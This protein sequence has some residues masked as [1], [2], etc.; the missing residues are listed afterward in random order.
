MGQIDPQLEYF[1]VRY[2]DYSIV[3]YIHLYCEDMSF[4]LPHIA[5]A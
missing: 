3:H 4:L 1:A 5:I 2:F